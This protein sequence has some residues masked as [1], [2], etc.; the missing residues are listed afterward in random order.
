MGV[1]LSIYASA[2]SLPSRSRVLLQAAPV[3]DDVEDDHLQA[4]GALHLALD[5]VAGDAVARAG[6]DMESAHPPGGFAGTHGGEGIVRGAVDQAHRG[7]RIF[8]LVHADEE[9]GAE[10][11]AQFLIFGAQVVPGKLAAQMLL[12]AGQQ[13]QV[14]PR[15]RIQLPRAPAGEVA[16][17][18]GFALPREGGDEALQFRVF[19]SGVHCCSS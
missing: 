6:E 16:Q 12:S 9:G 1:N 14:G 2:L 13:L 10:G 11:A 18:E 5:Q 7:G 4:G 15:A 19:G 17:R 8:A 3:G